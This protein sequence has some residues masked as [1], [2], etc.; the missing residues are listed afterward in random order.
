MKVLLTLQDA[1]EPAVRINA[2]AAGTGRRRNR[3]R[4]PAGRHPRRAQARE[5]PTSSFLLRLRPLR[6]RNRRDR[7]RSSSGSGAAAIGL[8]DLAD[9]VHVERLLRGLGFVDVFTKP[10]NPAEVVGSLRRILDRRRMQRATGLIGESDPMREVMV[11]V[12]EQMAPVSSTVLIEG[13]KRNGEGAR[14][15]RDSSIVEPPQQAVH[16]R[17]RRRASGD[18]ARK[19]ELFG[20]EKGRLHRRG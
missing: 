2:Q 12:S 13:R 8:S 18:A 4:L 6:S 11:Q 10:V 20:H 1:S 7:G 5:A 15:A 9:P 16:R 3:A 17:E 19:S 14:R